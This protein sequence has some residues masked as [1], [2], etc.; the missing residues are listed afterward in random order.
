MKYAIPV[1]PAEGPAVTQPPAQWAIVDLFGHSRYA[2]RISEQELAGSSFVRIDIPETDSQPA[3]SKL[4]GAAA[5]YSITFV[6]ETIARALAREYEI[7][8]VET[9]SIQ[10]LKDRIALTAANHTGRC[11]R[12]GVEADN[13]DAGVCADCVPY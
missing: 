12:C 3:F 4:F 10:K 8:P 6:T 11:I 1:Q 13:L 9:Y 5:V 7:R 2:G